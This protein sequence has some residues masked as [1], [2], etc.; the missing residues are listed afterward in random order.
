[1][2]NI[3]RLLKPDGIVLISTANPFYVDQYFFSAFRN[4]IIINPEHTCWI[5]PI[6]LN[7]LANRFGLD[8]FQI[9]WIKECWK[10][11]S[12]V[13]FN[14]DFSK[15]DV[16]KNK[17]IFTKTLSF[18]QNLLVS[19]VKLLLPFFISADEIKRLIVKYGDDFNNML[20]LTIKSKLFSAYWVF[21]QLFIPRSDLNK[22]ELYFAVLK[23]I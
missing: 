20:F 8:T 17:W 19:F 12:G 21:R 16:F 4:D 10:L 3:N 9:R 5:D 22:Y 13:I 1:M 18:H 14:D 23:K 15:L 2:N 7:Q 6:A 11:S